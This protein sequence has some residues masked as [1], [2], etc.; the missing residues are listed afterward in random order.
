[1]VFLKLNTQ[2][3]CAWG[4]DI[5]I[6]SKVQGYTDPIYVLSTEP[7]S[8]IQSTAVSAQ[9]KAIKMVIGKYK[10]LNKITKI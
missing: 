2:S 5:W 9:S 3:V 1:M 4:L 10:N 7:I 8:Y 6:S